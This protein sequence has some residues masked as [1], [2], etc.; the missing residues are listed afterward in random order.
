MSESFG[1]VRDVSRG[2]WL[3]PLEAEPFGSIL[4]IVPRGYEMYARVF[5]PLKRDRP[6]PTKTWQGIDEA[7][8]FKGFADI[9]SLLE[10]ERATWAQAATSFGT[11]MH[12][13]AQYARL[14]PHE[15][16]V[17]Q[18]AIAPDGWRYGEPHEGSLDATSLTA[19]A[20]VLAR[21]TSTP[22]AGIA[23]IW[24]GWGGLVSSVG[25]APFRRPVITL[26]PF[27]YGVAQR[28][29]RS[30]VPFRRA[31]SSRG[32]A[33]SRPRSLLTQSSAFMG[34]QAGSTF[35]SR[36]AQTIS[37][38]RGG[39]RGLHGWRTRHGP[40]PQHPVARGSSVGARDRNRR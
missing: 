26:T 38:T 14:V 7:T 2:E 31:Y 11:T 29:K 22:D 10:S 25:A 6:V 8:Y 17:V 1:Y 34:I 30:L 23:A 20:R 37:R 33:R 15:S 27:W 16:D 4:S 18:Q 32:R 12:P 24:S 35:S 5:H 36:R 28:L 19:T 9:D 40:S 21:H 39:P 13:E 3:R